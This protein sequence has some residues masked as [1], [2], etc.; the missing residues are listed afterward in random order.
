MI[1]ALRGCDAKLKRADKH[2][3]DMNVLI[4]AFKS[5]NPYGP[6]FDRN[7]NTGQCKL[8]LVRNQ[9]PDPDISLMVGDAVHN[10]RS[11]L[12]HFAYQWVLRRGSG[13]P[14]NRTQFPIFRFRKSGQRRGQAVT[15]YLDRV[16]TQ[17]PGI[18]TGS[19]VEAVFEATQPYHRRYRLLWA[20]HHLDILD[21][22]R[23][24][25][26]TSSR[27]ANQG[28][29][30]GNLWGFDIRNMSVYPTATMKKRAKIADFLLIQTDV[31]AVLQMNPKPTV[32]VVFG[33]GR[34]VSPSVAGKDVAETVKAARDLVNNDLFPR[35]AKLLK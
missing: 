17:L 33:K 30:I 29:G 16:A 11:A 7:L 13:S 12:D 6:V 35:L 2:I 15:G 32:H 20:V 4:D 14:D 1:S 3:A 31:N 8:Y 18:V 22:H 19:A 24:V 5:S 34:A 21:K 26:V 10:L 27:L 23:L 9:V 28:I 25:Q